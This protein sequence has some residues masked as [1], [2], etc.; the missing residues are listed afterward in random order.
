M[1]FFARNFFHSNRFKALTLT[2]ACVVVALAIIWIRI[3]T[4]KNT[5]AYIQNQKELNRLQQEVQVERVQ[6]LRLTS[7]RKLEV[8]ARHLGL[9]APKIDQII[10]LNPTPKVKVAV[11]P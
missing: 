2:F 1:A 9:S 8:L 3:A 7:P 11:R 4:V 5:Y 6:W 10:R